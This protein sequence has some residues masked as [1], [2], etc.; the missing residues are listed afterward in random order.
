MLGISFFA[1]LGVLFGLLGSAIAY[2]IFYREY[3]HHFTS[4]RRARNLALK[5]A[6][7]AF[8]FFVGL[9]IVSGYVIT[10]YIVRNGP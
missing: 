1:A 8:L 3:S 2:I 4:A 6:L 10:H 9:S 5:G 7:V